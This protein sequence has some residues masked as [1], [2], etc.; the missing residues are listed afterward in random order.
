MNAHSIPARESYRSR[1][2]CMCGTE[3]LKIIQKSTRFWLPTLQEGCAVFTKQFVHADFLWHKKKKTVQVN[4]SF[5]KT[6]S[7]IILY[8][9][10]G[11]QQS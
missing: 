7:T 6:E 10:L 2:Q 3:S 9:Q 5:L 8:K 11:P 1:Q 4:F